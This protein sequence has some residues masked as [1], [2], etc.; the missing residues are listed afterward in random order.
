MRLVLLF[1]LVGIIVCLNLVFCV[2]SSV[3]SMLCIGCIWL[4]SLS[5]LI[6]IVDFK[7]VCGI[8]LLVV[9]VVV[10]MVRLKCVLV[11]GRLVGVRLIVNILLGYD[12]FVV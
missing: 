4:F 10:V 2:V 9:S 11:F 7:R 12:N 5:F 1:W 8:F 6:R 3:G